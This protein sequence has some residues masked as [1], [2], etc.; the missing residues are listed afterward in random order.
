MSKDARLFAKF[1]LNFCDH[2]KIMILSDS[3]FR[4]LV[5][6]VLWS[7][8]QQTDGFLARRLALAKWSL[9]DLQELCAND[10]ANPSLIEREEGWYIHDYAQQQETKAEIEA[11]RERNRIN[12]QKGGLAKGKRT[13]KRVAKPAP[14]VPASKSGSEK[15]AEKEEEPRARDARPSCS[16]HS[17]NFNGPCPDCQ[18]R[19]EWDEARAEELRAAQAAEKRRIRDEIDDCAECDDFGRRAD[20][21]YCPLHDNFKE[22]R[23]A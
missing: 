3:A 2:P 22:A 6:A 7:R 8:E 5:S 18:R 1:T 15:L 13:A 11:R 4:C 10:D 9:A 16:R 14:G 21:T 20:L 23:G 17:Q 19:R 12:G